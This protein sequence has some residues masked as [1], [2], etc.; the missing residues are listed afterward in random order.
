M[1]KFIYLFTTS[2]ILCTTVLLLSRCSSK[3]EQL[4]IEEG[5]QYF[6]TDTGFYTIY[7]VDSVL[8]SS[9]L[10]GGVD[11]I[12]C[13][14][15][16]V[17]SNSFIDNE[18]REAVTVRRYVR[19][20]DS[21]NWSDIVPTVWYVVKTTSKAERMEGELRFIKMVFPIT[22]NRTWNGNIYLDTLKSD[23]EMYKNWQ[24]TYNNLYTNK[25]YN[26]LNF[27][28]TITINQNNY[29]DQ[30]NKN[31]STEIYAKNVGLVFREQ[32]IL[33]SI[34]TPTVWP[35]DA[36]DGYT[37]TQTIIDYKH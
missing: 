9:F 24:Y 26:G 28:S 3:T 4:L 15:K 8:Y 34:N 32:W 22:E 23:L 19:Y 2:I 14:L 33:K 17:L 25:T 35:Y 29:E 31:L 5:Y 1:T 11:T 6:P 10:S 27:D 7:N 13:Q 21:I 20:N 16:E 12:S 30:I 18:G 36:E 37:V